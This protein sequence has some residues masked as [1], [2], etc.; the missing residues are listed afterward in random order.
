MSTPEARRR[1]GEQQAALMHALVEQ[2]PVPAGFT[3]D[4]LHLAARSLVSKRREAVAR[5]WP[6]LAQALGG[7]FRERFNAFAIATSPPTE[8]G[9]LADGLAFAR[10]LRRQEFSDEARLEVLRVDL[11]YRWCGSGL[12]RRRG[13]T[14]RSAWLPGERRWVVGV[15][16]P[17]LGVRLL[18]V[19][20]GWWRVRRHGRITKR[21]VTS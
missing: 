4:R 20:F 12:V 9:P 7:R 3:P 16:L 17:W 15:R 5:V 2:G 21:P 18:R 1:L 6:A 11:R 14:L 19:P 10:T 13:F 8:G